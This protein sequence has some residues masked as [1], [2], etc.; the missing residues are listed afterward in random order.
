VRGLRIRA[1]KELGHAD[2]WPDLVRGL[3]PG[4]KMIA[5]K[6][7][8]DVVVFLASDRASAM[9]GHIV[10]ADAGFA[11]RSYGRRNNQ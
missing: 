4:G 7:I 6:E 5:P 11:A 1:E 8:A 10:T 9:T 3:F 2:K